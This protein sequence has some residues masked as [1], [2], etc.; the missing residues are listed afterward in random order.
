M[1]R[2]LYWGLVIFLVFVIGITIYK[3]IS[4]H[5]EVAEIEKDTG[6][7]ISKKAN[8]QSP[9]Q[10]QP[11]QKPLTN[12]PAES[13]NAEK[14]IIDT[15]LDNETTDT[16]KS[17]QP[18]ISTTIE[19]G[20]VEIADESPYGFGPYPEVPDD[21]IEKHGKPIWF[22]PPENLPTSTLRDVELIDRVK[23]SEVD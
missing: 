17:E 10:T 13:P 22:N 15:T 23:N 8:Q 2:K 4:D 21:F 14:T 12:T 9:T 11:T 1:N 3:V 20:Y 5:Q 19:T 18:P 6:P 7:H 16:N